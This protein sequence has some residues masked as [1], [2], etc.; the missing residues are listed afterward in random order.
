MAD[1]EQLNRLLDYLL[2][3]SDSSLTNELLPLSDMDP[4]LLAQF[5]PVWNNRSTGERRDLLAIMGRLTDT[6]I[7]LQFDRIYQAAL[8]DPDSEVRKLAIEN[9]WES[10][11]QK[12]IPVYLEAVN[13]DPSNDVRIAAIGALGRYILLG[14]FSKIPSEAL[15]MIEDTL[16][17][18]VADEQQ[19][20]QQRACIEALGYSSRPGVD[21][22][23]QAAYLSVDEAFRHSS[24][25]A[26]G[27]SANDRWI[28]NIMAE[29]VSHSPELRA[30]AARATGQLEIRLAVSSLFELLDDVND[31]VRK[32]AI[33][34]MGQIGGIRAREALEALQNSDIDEGLNAHVEE[35]LEHI[36]FLEG[37]PDFLL[38]DFD[39]DEDEL[40]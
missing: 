35:A 27:R 26:M 3:E 36:A 13:S 4:A 38:Y 7:E 2:A 30:E 32:N 22:I 21:D 15:I 9:L 11:D 24:L 6:R 18:L 34:S 23:I 8:N 37:T 20:I 5:Q 16:L 40:T 33:W 14:Q 1:A 19:P 28:D 31:E 17:S 29:L 12:L 10:E 39:D 25:I